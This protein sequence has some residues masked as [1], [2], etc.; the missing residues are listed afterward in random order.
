M[1]LQTTS[2]YDS[3]ERFSNIIFME[4][5]FKLFSCDDR[6]YICGVG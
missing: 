3:F 2:L 4:T 1:L 5:R 6:F